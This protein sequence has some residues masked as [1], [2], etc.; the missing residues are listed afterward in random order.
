[1]LHFSHIALPDGTLVSQSVPI[2]LAVSDE[3]KQKCADAPEVALTFNDQPVATMTKPTFFEHRK[4]E[5][6]GRTWGFT[7]PGI[8]YIDMIDKEGPWLVGGTLSVLGREAISYNDGL[9]EYRKTPVE[10]RE[11]FARRG[12][13]AVY[14]FQLRNPVHNGKCTSFPP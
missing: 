8:P 11:E 3:V 1:M 12:A 9:D 6:E 13:D 14:A 4:E 5:R 2:V 10:L 7:T